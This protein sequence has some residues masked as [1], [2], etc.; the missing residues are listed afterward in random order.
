MTFDGI[1]FNDTNDPTPHSW[2]WFPTPFIGSTVFDRSP[3][4]A[5]VIGPATSGGSINILSREL[6]VDQNVEGTISYGSFNTRMLSLDKPV[7]TFQPL[8]EHSQSNLRRLSDLQ[9]S[10]SLG[11]VGEIS[12]QVS[13]RTVVTAYTGVVDLA[14]NTPNVKG[15]TRAQ[16]AVR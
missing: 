4:D 11:R 2:F 6:T 13:D 8:A 15:P 14:S 5:T 10:G 9:L 1:R 16:V 12:V 7:Q 3:G